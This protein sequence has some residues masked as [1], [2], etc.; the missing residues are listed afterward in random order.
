M[1]NQHYYANIHVFISVHFSGIKFA[2]D[3]LALVRFT[4]TKGAG[5]P[6]NYLIICVNK[7]D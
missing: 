1:I 5:V 2:S 3:G 6:E 7:L 4:L